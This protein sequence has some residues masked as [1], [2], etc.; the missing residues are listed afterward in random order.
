MFERTVKQ[1]LIKRD[2]LSRRCFLAGTAGGLGSLALSILMDPILLSAS[3]SAFKREAGGIKELPHFSPTAKRVICLFQSGG[4]SHVDLFEDKPALRKFAGEEI[5]ASIKGDQRLTGM[6]SGQSAYP[7]VP[8]I[9]SGKRCGESGTWISDLLP[10]LQTVA[11]ELAMIKSVNTEAINHDPA[12]TF[13]N[14]GNQQPGYP[15]MGAWLSYGLGSENAELPA[16][17]A[18]TSQG[19]GKN[20][21]Q[22]IFSRLWGN[23]FLPSSHQGVGLRP[24]ANPVLYLSNPPGT[25]RNQRR[26]MLDDLATLN[27][28]QVEVTGDPETLTRIQAYEMAFRMQM[29]VPELTNISNETTATLESYGPDVHRPGSYAANCLL[30]RRL[31]ERD[32]RFV[33][34]YHRGWDQHIALNRQL[35]NQCRDVDQPTAALIKD[36]KQRGLL[37]DTL[38]LFLTE[39]GR[40]SFSQGKFGSPGA[41]RDHHG[42]CFTCWM[43]GGG[44]K[45]GIEFGQTDDFAYNIT[46]N[47]VHLR[48]LHATLMHCMGIDHN[49]FSFR[50]RGLHSRLTGV[51]QANVVKK[52]LL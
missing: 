30:A 27:R 7:I 12:V 9:N 6:T 15:S 39:F 35:P 13:M 4:A 16:F 32:V 22:P 25:N 40:T 48:D 5:P 33:Q 41:G 14:T 37:Q 17:I 23:G 26:K 2:E 1:P 51:E 18:M 19:S 45:P 52:I 20:P 34:L 47:P 28:A 43:A 31:A 10:Q 8:P 38:V 44:V 36:L 29:S 3:A 11:G 42:R 46:E 50:F 21:G 49:R 24:G